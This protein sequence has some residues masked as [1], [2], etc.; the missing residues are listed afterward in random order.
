MSKEM[1]FENFF[2]TYVSDDVDFWKV[3]GIAAK[4]DLRKQLKISLSLE[5]DGVDEDPEGKYPIAFYG[6]VFP[7]LL[8]ELK[9][10]TKSF[11]NYAIGIKHAFRL[12]FDNESDDDEDTEKVGTTSL[13]IENDN[14]SVFNDIDFEDY[15]SIELCKQ[16]NTLYFDEQ[17]NIFA[18][19]GEAAMTR[20]KQDYNITVSSYEIIM[21]IFTIIHMN[22]VNAL[23]N[24]AKASDQSEYEVSYAGIY[25]IGIRMYEDETDIYYIPDAGVKQFFK[26]DSR[27]YRVGDYS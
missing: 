2:D 15:N 16:F 6:M 23:I 12:S 17:P 3:V 5:K 21:P 1:N 25:K 9:S 24:Y 8:E 19:I 7:L 26:D 13:L 11:K 4:K 14:T 10:K 27:E 20:L 18:K 22:I